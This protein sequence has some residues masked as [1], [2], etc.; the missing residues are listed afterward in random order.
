MNAIKIYKYQLF[1]YLFIIIFSIQ[2]TLFLEFNTSFKIHK[3]IVETVFILSVV[4]TLISVIILII[5]TIKTLNK[6]IIVSKEVVF[7]IINIILYYFVIMSS[8]YLS[9]LYP[10]Y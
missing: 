6:K 1:L 10:S 4:T 5:Q 7:L 3:E 9:K 8:L 2:N